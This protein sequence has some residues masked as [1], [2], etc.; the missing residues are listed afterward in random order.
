VALAAITVVRQAKPN[1]RRWLT[2]LAGAGLV[3]HVGTALIRL[4]TLVPHPRPLDFA[5]YYFSA[6]KV[7][8]D[9]PT[10]QASP[11]LLESLQQHQG[12]SVR[13]TMLNSPPVWPW[14][15][16]PLT[17][18]RFPVAAW[19]WVM[20]L[21]G[22]VAWSAM[23]LAHVSGCCGWK[24]TGAVFLIALTFGP[25]FLALTLG[26][27]SPFLLLAALA[28]GRAIRHPTARGYLSA[29]VL[30]VIAVAAKLFPLVWLGALLLLRRWRPLVVALAAALCLLA[31][32]SFRTAPSNRAYWSRWLPR[33][34]AGFFENSSLDDQSLT[35]W[36]DRV[37]RPR[38]FEVPGLSVRERRRVT[39]SS[40]W[41]PEARTI[42]VAGWVI[43]AALGLIVIVVVL[44]Q[45][46]EHTEA[47]L[48][49]WVLY[50]LVVLPHIE[51]YDHV[52]LLPAMAW[53]WAHGEA[54]KSI[55]TIGYFLAGL[56]RL[57]HLWAL[58]LPAPWGPLASGFGLYTVLLLGGAMIRRLWVSRHE[59]M[60]HSRGW[61][62][63]VSGV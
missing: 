39:W 43:S 49:L 28:A 4:E 27:N 48:Y 50:T 55:A 20:I 36:L 16:Q 26:Q 14:L 22:V 57:S 23:I 32:G 9:M 18:L 45:G 54:G 44:K 21:V 6:W 2:I 37:V 24:Q 58:L 31:L 52:L 25:T 62:W 35:A 12:L 11:Q 10:V 56:S 19:L 15:L 38:T 63:A 5:S 59:P 53:L 13:P 60:D 17:L 30:W 1:R 46:E 33:V 41:S 61:G 34:T 47:A 8:L 40:P 7:R 51:R 29:A 42:T 3:M